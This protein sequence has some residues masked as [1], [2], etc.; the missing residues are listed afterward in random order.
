MILDNIGIHDNRTKNVVN[1]AKFSWSF[2]N[3]AVIA[4]IAPRYPRRRMYLVSIINLDCFGYHF[5]NPS[6]GMHYFYFCC[7]HCLDYS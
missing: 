2:V 1:L 3:G 4:L 7:I 5:I 6:A